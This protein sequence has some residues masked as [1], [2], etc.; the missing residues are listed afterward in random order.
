[1]ALTS[2]VNEASA[3]QS[4]A[5]QA[6]KAGA[7]GLPNNPPTVAPRRDFASVLSEVVGAGDKPAGAQAE[8][9]KPPRS[10]ATETD[11]AS[12]EKASDPPQA[13][14]PERITRNKESQAQP[15]AG[16]D[17]GLAG[18]IAVNQ[19]QPLKLD[20][21]VA[22]AQAILPAADME[23]ILAA[24]R[25]QVL[26]GGH[27]AVTLDLQRS[28]LE[29]LRI[30]LT[31]DP[32]GRIAVEFLANSEAVKGQI[33]ARAGELVQMFGAHGVKLETLQSSVGNASTHTGDARSRQ[34]REPQP[35]LAGIDKRPRP[36]SPLTD[37]SDDGSAF[38]SNA[39]YRA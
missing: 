22:S 6:A 8:N 14:E 25:T 19:P 29:G 34:G 35:A 4:R 2:N 39:T 16:E 13:R 24:I 26:P 10:S 31:A 23:R 9:G 12:R 27:R 32:H 20:S 21:P 1:M 17:E 38:T 3:Y 33:D 28:V 5:E 18:G 30:K 36:A 7:P 15:Q 11:G 37:D